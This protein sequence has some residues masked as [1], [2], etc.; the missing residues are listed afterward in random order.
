MFSNNIDL[1]NNNSVSTT[2]YLKASVNS[3][4]KR[5]KGWEN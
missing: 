2:I 4:I 3:L 1:I 5:L